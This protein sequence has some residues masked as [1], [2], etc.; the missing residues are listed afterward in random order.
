MR[1][2]IKKL[3]GTM[4]FTMA[5]SSVAP[6]GAVF[7]DDLDA[8]IA[9][10]GGDTMVSN[11]TLAVGRTVDFRFVGAPA[12]WAELD[13]TWSSSIPAVATVDGAG[14]VTAKKAGVTT[15]TIALSNGWMA[16]AKVVVE[17]IPNDPEAPVYLAFQNTLEQVTDAHVLL[18]TKDGVD[19]WFINAPAGW[20]KMNP[21]WK[22]ADE[23][24]ATVDGAGIVRGVA[25]GAT[26][27]TFSLNDEVVASVDIV[28][29]DYVV[30][31]V[32]E[33]S[34]IGAYRAP[35]TE[36]E[37]GYIYTLENAEFTVGDEAEVLVYFEGVLN[38]DE[39]VEQYNDF[40]W[41]SSDEEVA[42]VEDGVLVA[43]GAGEATLTATGVVAGAWEKEVEATITV[44][45][46]VV[47]ETYTIAQATD[48][49][50]VLTFADAEV[51]ATVT[52]D[53]VKMAK[54]R[55]TGATAFPIK[56]VAVKDDKVTITVYTA[57]ADGDKFIVT[58]GEEEGTEF[59][60]T[61]G[62]VDD[63]VVSYKSYEDETAMTG[64]ADKAYAN[65]EDENS[66]TVQLSAKIF[67]NNVDVT[68][69]AGY[70]TDEKCVEYE[71]EGDYDTDEVE[72]DENVLT[73][74]KA[75]VEVVV[76][77]TYTYEDAEEKEQVVEV[78]VPIVSEAAP[79][80][81]VE[82]IVDWTFVTA[83]QDKIDWSKTV[84]DVPA[85]DEVYIVAL[86]EDSYGNVYVTNSKFA[87][88]TYKAIE[89][90]KFDT[91]GYS[92]SFESTDV[93]KMIV[94]GTEVKTWDTAT[95]GILVL[96]SNSETEKTEEIYCAE[97]KVKAARTLASVTVNK[98]SVTLPTDGSYTGS[99]VEIK[100]ADQYGA[101]WKAD[102]EV[103][104]STKASV[105]NKTVNLDDVKV[106]VSGGKYEYAFD[107]SELRDAFGKAVTV[108]FTVKAGSK[109][110]NFEVVLKTPNAS[111]VTYGL[112]ASSISQTVAGD[113]TSPIRS[114][115]I[116]FYEYQS[117]LKFGKADTQLVAS[118]GALKTLLESTKADV[119]EGDKFLVVYKPD[120]KVLAETATT[121]AL[122]VYDN[123]DGTYQ[124]VVARATK[125]SVVSNDSLKMD[126]AATGTYTAKVLVVT[127]FNS[128]GV[129][130]FDQKSYTADFKVTNDNKAVVAS[131]Q[132]K[133]ES[134]YTEIEDIVVD[135]VTFT[136]G[137][138]TWKVGSAW[139]QL[140]AANIIA[141][142]AIESTDYVVIKSV[143]VKVPVAEGVA[144]TF[145]EVTVPVKMTV[146]Y[147]K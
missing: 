72:I 115:T 118:E 101:D 30:E 89:E 78:L 141:V 62:Y 44:K 19:F 27:I 92:V 108:K 7:A 126:Y 133:L 73:F 143:T 102:T 37:E 53:T 107:G 48:K 85:G 117:K 57:F 64:G 17:E 140:S 82:G 60:A 124:V 84:K 71:I 58:V 50:I 6:A 23:T 147:A 24:V 104:I 51:A 94:D 52:K 138:S 105:D 28:V 20:E 114:N 128:K 4:A 15:I 103:T 109:S 22:S 121:N 116:A 95:A 55:A 43:V 10:Q 65:A 86:I 9:M 91:E 40:A 74:Y 16:T 56:E 120:G 139:N 42:K 18:N 8:F 123:G 70:I 119:K 130:K 112:E 11:I 54:V 90:S 46:A 93:A 134:E 2:F 69:A 111:K 31:D 145:Y 77:A 80:Y 5:V 83:S 87:N 144:D 76:K 35:M 68:S 12:N 13:P 132:A 135:A 1:S 75:G 81:K 41:V 96:L 39:F 113:A 61:L 110:D 33:T 129:A 137:G 98:D 49:Q 59:T 26:T 38:G 36:E 47:D 136:L 122:G 131:K 3:A 142:D 99:K 146:K 25:D 29:G 45:E 127:G 21:T 67:A 66:I 14:I 106:T 79:V 34:F 97:V 32:L 88:D 125:S 63:I 100:L